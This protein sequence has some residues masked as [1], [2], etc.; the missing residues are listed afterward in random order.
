MDVFTYTVVDPHQA[1]DTAQLRITIDGRN[2][3]P[4]AVDDD[5]LAIEA[6]GIGNNIPG[7]NPSGNVLDNDTDVDST[8]LGETRQVLSVTSETGSNALAGQVL[9]GR[10]GSLVLNA[11]G[12][13]SYLLDNANPTVQ[14]LR[15]AGQTLREVFT[16]RMRDTAGAESEARLNVLIQ[17]ADDAPVARDDSTVASDQTPSPQATGNVLPNDSDVDADEQLSVSGIRTGA[18][19]GSGTAGTVGQPLAGRY[20]TLVINAD[21]SYTYSID[22]NNPEVLAAAGL[23]RVL[24]DVFTYTL[25]DRAGATD[26]AQ[27]TITLDIAAPFIPAPAGPFFGRDSDDPFQRLPLHDVDPVVFIGP[28]V[29]RQ[30]RILELS[31]WQADGSNLSYGRT[32]EILSETLN[33]RLG[34]IPGQFVARAVQGSRQASESDMA[35]IL[36]RQSRINLSADGLLPDPSVFATDAAHLTQGDTQLPPPS[37]ARIASGFRAQ[38]REAAERLRALDNRTRE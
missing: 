2:D 22:L 4:I 24:Q 12:S 23:G 7:L 34:L 19:T 5:T 35:W 8:A 11:D 20:G 33:Q 15:T 10:Y 17:G 37:E 28:V 30:E 21:G 18:E 6:G 29:E 36:G 27:L 1:D 14:A 16:Y 13:Y 38:L 26:L 32:P 25:S 3:T 9:I 31:G